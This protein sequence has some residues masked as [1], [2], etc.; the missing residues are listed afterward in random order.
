MTRYWATHDPVLGYIIVLWL[1]LVVTSQSRLQEPVAQQPYLAVPF[2]LNAVLTSNGDGNN[3]SEME[4][5]DT[6]KNATKLLF[7]LFL[8]IL[9]PIIFGRD[10]QP[11]L[12]IG[13]HYAIERDS[14]PVQYNGVV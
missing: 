4:S 12:L 8:T 6:A 2:I 3:G 5:D 13:R 14:A 11:A 1:T 7:K 9:V 10:A